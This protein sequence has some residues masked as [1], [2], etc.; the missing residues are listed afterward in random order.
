MG[1]SWIYIACHQENAKGVAM[2]NGSN[3][4]PVLSPSINSCPVVNSLCTSALYSSSC[5]R[6]GEILVLVPILDVSR[7]DF[8]YGERK[9]VDSAAESPF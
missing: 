4:P 9:T 7:V 8:F 3:S 6:G 2:H 1:F 5:P